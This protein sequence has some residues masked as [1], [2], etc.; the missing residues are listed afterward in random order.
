MTSLT[1]PA[2]SKPRHVMDDRC[3][4]FPG[5]HADYPRRRQTS[6]ALVI[7]AIRFRA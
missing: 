4:H 5:L 1:F 7:E 3:P 2:A 6:R